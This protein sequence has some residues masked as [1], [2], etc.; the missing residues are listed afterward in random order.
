MDDDN[1]GLTIVR[2]GVA[3]F[4]SM[5]ASSS[6]APT[7]TVTPS[8]SVDVPRS[9][10]E[11]DGVSYMEETSGVP[12]NAKRQG[13]KKKGKGKARPSGNSLVAA[14][15]VQTGKTHPSRKN[16]KLNKWADKCMYAE[17]LEMTEGFS[18][19]DVGR[20]GIPDDIETGWVAVTPVPLGKRCL[21]VTH[22]ASGVA[23]VGM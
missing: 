1:E 14:M 13:K 23:G 16:K 6:S 22:Q 3:Q 5:L 15:D 7:P 12:A 21:A 11:A 20:D 4:A 17:L 8:A 9:L 2:D 19:A 18:T 10:S